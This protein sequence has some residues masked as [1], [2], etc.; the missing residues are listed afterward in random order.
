MQQ[1]NGCSVFM[2]EKHESVGLCPGVK[3]GVVG[4]WGKGVDGQVSVQSSTD[5]LVVLTQC[6]T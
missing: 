6:F 1:S 4:V 5:A 3:W 2:Q